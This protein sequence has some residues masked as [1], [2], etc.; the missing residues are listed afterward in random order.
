M[1]ETLQVEP[2]VKDALDIISTRAWRRNR[3]CHVSISARG[4]TKN[5]EYPLYGAY[6]NQA[7]LWKKFFFEK[8]CCAVLDIKVIW[9]KINHE[10]ILKINQFYLY[11]FKAKLFQVSKVHIFWEGHKILRNLPFNFD[12][13][14]YSQK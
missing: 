1:E 4:G 3:W 13:S 5:T 2:L 12:Y 9:A 8:K 14:T 6:K 11:S 10:K 7:L